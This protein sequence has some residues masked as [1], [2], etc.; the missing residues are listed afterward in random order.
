MH[1]NDPGTCSCHNWLHPNLSHAQSPPNQGMK[2]QEKPQ[3]KSMSKF[4]PTYPVSVQKLTKAVL[5][6]FKEKLFAR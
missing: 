4:S 6:T 3:T 2:Y 5:T 1:Q